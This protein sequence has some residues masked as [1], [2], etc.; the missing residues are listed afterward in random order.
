M[1]LCC[2]IH[3]IITDIFMIKYQFN[4]I[5]EKDLKFYNE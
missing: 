1:D 2:I 5:I 3:H 4:I